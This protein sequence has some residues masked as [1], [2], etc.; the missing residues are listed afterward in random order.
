[1]ATAKKVLRVISKNRNGSMR[2]GR[3]FSGATP[4]DLTI[5]Q[6]EPKNL[7]ENEITQAQA[8]QI[9][10]CNLLV[11][12]T[13]PEG[14]PLSDSEVDKLKADHATEIEG[15]KADHATEITGLN[16]QVSGL[17]AEITKLKA[18]PTVK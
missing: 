15:L 9:Q 18:P 8:K 2:A 5:T 12:V 6:K 1:M 11:A 14:A 16:A 17:E 10:G 3:K 4:V 13:V 7:G